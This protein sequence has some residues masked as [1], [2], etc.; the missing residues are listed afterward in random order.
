MMNSFNTLSLS[1]SKLTNTRFFDDAIYGGWFEVW[2]GSCCEWSI[3]GAALKA[4]P[5]AAQEEM[6]QT[7]RLPRFRRI[8][9]VGD[10]RYR[11]F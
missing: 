11:V 2:F 10:T 5:R 9:R 8:G 1:K 6:R 7:R 4:S 3:T